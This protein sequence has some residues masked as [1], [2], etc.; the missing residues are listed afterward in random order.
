[1]FSFRDDFIPAVS[2]GMKRDEKLHI[3]SLQ[4]MLSCSLVTRAPFSEPFFSLIGLLSSRV[5]TINRRFRV[6][7][8]VPNTESFGR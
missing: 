3:N 6:T 7:T 5:R 4:G 2:A 1:M 8:L